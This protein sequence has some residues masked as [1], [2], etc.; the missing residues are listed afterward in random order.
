MPSLGTASE[1]LKFDPR[2]QK[3]IM[4]GY[5][6]EYGDRW[7]GRYHV[8]S[9]ESL[10]AF[11]DGRIARPRVH[12]TR[13]VFCDT[14]GAQVEFPAYV[15]VSLPPKKGSRG[16]TD[17]MP[18][19][20]ES[21][22]AEEAEPP[23]SD[24]VRRDPVDP[25]PEGPGHGSTDGEGPS[26]LTPRPPAPAPAGSS[27][28]PWPDQRGKAEIIDNQTIRARK[29][30]KR[31]PKIHPDVWYHLPE[32]TR[33]QWTEEYE[34]SLRDHV[35][36]DPFGKKGSDAK[37]ARLAFVE[38]HELGASAGCR[39]IIRNLANYPGA[40]RL[41][42]TE[43]NPT[44]LVR[45]SV[46]FEPDPP[47]EPGSTMVHVAEA[48]PDPPPPA[49]AAAP[50]RNASGM[51]WWS[52]DSSDDWVCSQIRQ[53]STH[54]SCS[55]VGH[56]WSSVG[57]R[58]TFR[59]S[60]GQQLEHSARGP[61]EWESEWYSRPIAR[62]GQIVPTLTQWAIRGAAP[63][64]G[65]RVLNAAHSV[66][67]GSTDVET[68]TATLGPRGGTETVPGDDDPDGVFQT[69][70]D[71]CMSSLC[72]EGTDALFAGSNELYAS[73]DY[74]DYDP[75]IGSTGCRSSHRPLHPRVAFSRVAPCR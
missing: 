35:P 6:M 15:E 43:A 36:W 48:T 53:D 18:S 29:G 42:S 70:I 21:P 75:G 20:R 22:G 65:A 69:L 67:R 58:R 39:S 31:P 44:Q 32:Q 30:T 12:D 26:K 52:Q 9:I 1:D 57:E 49:A 64:P 51:I 27:T 37:T 11:R 72:F 10:R 50:R 14:I 41:G 7:S 38:L 5:V 73:E 33:K 17:D 16:S 45:K 61:Y 59:L 68:K 54:F 4:L 25:F 56:D 34:K 63:P 55:P 60:D 71:Q 74:A 40:A 3:G 62:G 66:A 46:R 23:P 47:P 2:A 13:E 28:D 19:K 8:M 24:G